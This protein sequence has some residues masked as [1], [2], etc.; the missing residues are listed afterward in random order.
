MA[1]IHTI[2]GVEHQPVEYRGRP[3]ARIVNGVAI[4]ADIDASPR[5]GRSTLSPSQPQSPSAPAKTESK[6][7][8]PSCFQAFLAW[9]WSLFA[10][11]CPSKKD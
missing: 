3:V 11:C 10:F 4:P 6:Q 5:N 2:R 1:A 7:E 9:F 8:K